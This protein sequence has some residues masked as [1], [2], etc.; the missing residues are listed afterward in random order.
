MSEV[1]CPLCETVQPLS[2]ECRECGGKLPGARA[3]LDVLTPPM[4]DLELTALDTS[5]ADA[6]PEAVPG[7]EL[8]PL[9][10]PALDIVDER[11]PDMTDD[12]RAVDLDL[13]TPEPQL[14]TCPYCGSPVIGRVCDACGRSVTKV[15]PPPKGGQGDGRT[16]LVCPGC[17]SKVPWVEVCEKCKTPLPLKELF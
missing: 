13:P 7:L 4:V 12:D 11:L 5:G 6:P 1:A 14:T 17:Q 10:D 3:A 9:A 16:E 2:L 8:T 15:A